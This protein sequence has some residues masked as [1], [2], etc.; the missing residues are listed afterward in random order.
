MRIIG[1]STSGGL[2]SNIG[3]E[4]TVYRGVTELIER[5]AVNIRWTS[6]IA[7]E[8]IILDKRFSDKKF[9]KFIDKSYRLGETLTFY[10][11]SLDI[12]VPVVSVVQI[13]QNYKRYA[14][15]AGGGVDVELEKAMFSAFKE[16]GQ[17]LEP[18]LFSLSSPKTSYANGMRRML[19]VSP[20]ADI[21]N[22]DHFFKIMSY[23]GYENKIGDLKSYLEDGKKI[24]FSEYETKLRNK[25][26]NSNKYKIV[27]EELK[28]NNIDPIYFDFT[29]KQMKNNK[30][31]KV[32]I[33][34]LAPPYLHSK[35]FY[36]HRR[37]YELP[38][39]LGYAEKKLTYDELNKKAIPYP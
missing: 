1:Y 25:N 27:C 38:M 8:K 11:H 17:S 10:N 23:Y 19:E 31:I 9:N 3:F 21:R 36:G 29:P 12:L 30:I 22:L 4:E 39:K 18:I 13:N 24:K 33:P 15:V 34:E 14:F 5:D 32:F 37:Y 20:E 16:Y 28:K 26:N 7:P 6:K 2:A 35:P